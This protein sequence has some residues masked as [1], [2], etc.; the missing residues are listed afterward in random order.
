MRVCIVN[1]DYYRSSGITI[2]IK[3]IHFAVSQSGIENFFVSCDA[4]NTKQDIAWMSE[5]RLQVF[6]LMSKNPFLLSLELVRFFV[7]LKDNRIDVVHVHHRRLAIIF[8]IFRIFIDSSLLYS[9][10]LTYKFNIIFWLFSPRNVIAVTSS[11]ADNVKLTARPLRI[12]IIGNPTEFPVDYA[13]NFQLV[14][15]NQAICVARLDPVKGHKH[16]IDAWGLLAKKGLFYRLFLIGEGDLLAP[17][18]HRVEELGLDK[19]IT[20]LGYTVNVTPFYEKSLFSILVSEVEGQGI[21]TIEA[22]AAGRASLL[23]DVDGSRD[24]LPP[25]RLLP[26]GLQYGNV[27]ALADTIEYWF[28]HPEAVFEEGFKFFQFHK[29][30]NSFEAI[31]A[32]Y[33]NAYKRLMK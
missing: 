1:P 27:T 9:A 21:V 19:V 15:P 5:G 10:N 24:C 7:W 8:S 25:D 14:N 4:D 22:A 32:K 29:I 13:N 12:E 26:N 28:K 3:R 23:T 31:G 30:L 11:V 33:A 6:N 2:A 16:L 20:F 17:L 18:R